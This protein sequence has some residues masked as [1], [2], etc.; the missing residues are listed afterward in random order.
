MIQ[1]HLLVIEGQNKGKRPQ[2]VMTFAKANDT[3]QGKSKTHAVVSI[4][5]SKKNTKR[6]LKANQ[7]SEMNIHSELPNEYL[8]SYNL[9]NM[10]QIMT[11]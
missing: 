3:P 10:N 9:M 7:Y 4:R 8:D 5:P 11:K 6:Q 2:K 1:F